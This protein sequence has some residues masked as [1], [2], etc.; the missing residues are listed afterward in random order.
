M[1]DW[2]KCQISSLV[3]YHQNQKPKPKPYSKQVYIR[4]QFT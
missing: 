2:L 1:Q 4:N 3:N